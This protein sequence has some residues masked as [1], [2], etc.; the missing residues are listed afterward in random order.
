MTH[1]LARSW[2]T[3]AVMTMTLAAVL[4]LPVIADAAV[5]PG[6]YA[7]QVHDGDTWN[8]VAVLPFSTQYTTGS[9]TLPAETAA[10]RLVQSG[11]TAAQLD[12][13]TLDGANVIAVAGA[14]DVGATRLLAA[15]DNDVTNVF[16]T[17]V[18]VMF[19]TPGTRLGVRARVQGSLSGCLPF[20]YPLANLGGDVT[21]GSAFYTFD[22][23]ALPETVDMSVEPLVSEFTE[24]GTGHPAGYTRIW[25][26]ASDQSLLVTLDFT[27]DNTVDDDEDFATVHVKTGDGVR[28]F[29]V[30]A[31]EREWGAVDFTYTDAVSYRHKLYTFEVPWDAVGGRAEEVALAFTTYGTA[32][33]VPVP[34]EVHRFYRPASGAHVY[35]SDP[36]EGST[37]AAH[38]E[39]GYVYDG[40]AYHLDI[41]H[42][43]MS[44]PL[45]RFYHPVRRTHFFTASETE[46]SAV[47]SHPEWG[48]LYEG[49]AYPVSTE[50]V[51][52]PVHRYRNKANGSHFYTTNEAEREFLDQS[53]P[54]LYQYEGIGFYVLP[55]AEAT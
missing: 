28:S 40:L 37:I 47:Q 55:M 20:Q 1:P 48:Y 52:M 30:S 46:K 21:A 18:V 31:N 42:P 41:G 24:P 45:Y 8:T 3:W 44:Q 34:L 5:A 36:A 10:V 27:S 29:R 14:G 19:D 9:V 6:S 51:F 4:A 53:L 7:V 26:A 49:V 39:W 11:G 35:T 15:A 2:R 33:Y 54:H 25:A 22:A 12:A 38:P 32:A 16:D 17:A 50:P 13:V 23:A 43:W